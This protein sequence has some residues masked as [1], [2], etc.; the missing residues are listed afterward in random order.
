MMKNYFMIVQEVQTE[1]LTAR[2][3]YIY[4]DTSRVNL[5]LNT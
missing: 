3:N 1:L 2:L 5:S 4:V